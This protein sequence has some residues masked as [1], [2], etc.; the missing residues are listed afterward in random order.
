VQDLILQDQLYNI[1]I[2]DE[3]AILNHGQTGGKAD[4]EAE[5]F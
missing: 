1:A 5:C 3:Y 2:T 4:H